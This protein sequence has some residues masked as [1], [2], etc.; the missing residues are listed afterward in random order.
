MANHP[1]IG[2]MLGKECT[3]HCSIAITLSASVAG[4]IPPSSTG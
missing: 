2:G 4:M 1:F 3:A